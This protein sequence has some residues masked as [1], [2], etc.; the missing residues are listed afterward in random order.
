MQPT[1]YQEI[2]QLK[3]ELKQWQV[4]VKRER[5]RERKSEI[6]RKIEHTN[7]IIEQHIEHTNKQTIFSF[8]FIFSSSSSS[9]FSCVV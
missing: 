4:K 1:P 5:E 7:N 8:S 6:N 9:S 3:Q 2:N